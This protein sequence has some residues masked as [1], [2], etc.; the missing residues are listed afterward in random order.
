MHVESANEIES[1]DTMQKIN[2]TD[3]DTEYSL[4]FK[5]VYILAK[6]LQISQAFISATL[7]HTKHAMH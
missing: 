6:F 5:I 4:Y 7:S 3:V 1:C 2:L